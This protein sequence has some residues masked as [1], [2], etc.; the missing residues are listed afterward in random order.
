[1]LHPECL[2][3]WDH[4][5]AESYRRRIDFTSAYVATDKV[6]R[7]QVDAVSATLSPVDRDKFVQRVIALDVMAAMLRTLETRTSQEHAG[8]LRFKGVQLRTSAIA[9]LVTELAEGWRLEPKFLDL[10][11]LRIAV[12]RER[13]A[14]RQWAESSGGLEADTPTIPWDEAALLAIDTFESVTGLR[15]ELWAILF[16]ELEIVP[17]A[18]RSHI[19]GATRGMDRRLLLKCSLSP[20]LHD[21]N[22]AVDE[23]SGTVFND[24]N[25]IKLFYGR[26]SESYSFSRQII[27]GRLKAAGLVPK[28]DLPIEEAVFGASR[29]TGD[30]SQGKSR[31]TAAAY[32]DSGT[33]GQVV[34]ALAERD[35]DF[36]DWLV[37]QRI[38]PTRLSSISEKR[39][40]ETLRKARNIIIARLEFR[41]AGGRDL[42]GQLRS[43]KTMAMYTGGATMLDI[44]EGNPRFLLGL[45]VPLLDH[46]DGT[47]PIPEQRQADALN[48]I[49]DDFYA[50]I[51]AI[52]V[53]PDVRTLPEFGNRTLR[54]PYRE[55]IDRIADFFQ[56]ATLRGRFDP[57]PPSTFRVPRDASDSLQILIGRLVNMGAVV[58]V[59]DRGIKDVLIGQFD[60]NRLRL[61]YLVAAREHLPP[62]VDRPVSIRRVLAREGETDQNHELPGLFEDE[63]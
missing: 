13:L 41:R 35:S 17:P 4:P 61:C 34:K 18:V 11:S 40:A 14:V 42:S 44:C 31:R 8:G 26:R 37:S 22:L 48:Q 15:D 3:L 23:H 49:A 38:D 20:W 21:Q 45:L 33:L 24:F 25:V 62:N 56:G 7:Q 32:R 47:H 43:R 1:M 16:D 19:L 53:S 59:P 9:T 39:R 50:L 55:L 54:H 52:P 58:I 2:Q 12:R 29:F 10:G 27:L 46:Y 51:D 60:Q 36:N 5:A 57:Q 30:D 6:W 28:G 63:L